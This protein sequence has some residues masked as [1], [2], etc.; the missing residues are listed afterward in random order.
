MIYFLLNFNPILP[1]Y[2]SPK[3][4]GMGFS[5]LYALRPYTSA[6][7]NCKLWFTVYVNKI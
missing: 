5:T 1:N 4:E 3:N 7:S 2:P 6:F